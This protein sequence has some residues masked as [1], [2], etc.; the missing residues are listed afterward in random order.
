[1]KKAGLLKTVALGTAL[2]VGTAG[3]P[4]FAGD[5]FNS[6]DNYNSNKVNNNVESYQEQNQNQDQYQEQNQNQDQSQNAYGGAGGSADNTNNVAVNASHNYKRPIPMGNPGMS[7]GAVSGP[8]MGTWGLNVSVPFFGVG[9]HDSNFDKEC[10]EHDASATLVNSGDPAATAIGV[11]GFS[12]QYDSVKKGL[13]TV[14]GNAPTVDKSTAT[15][16][17]YLFGGGTQKEYVAP[18]TQ[19]TSGAVPVLVRN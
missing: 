2:L 17:D 19:Q 14:A 1:M 11:V 4:V 16:G 8:C 5:N 10:G 13:N 18:Q 9:G 7:A 6:L 12:N 15:A 3:T